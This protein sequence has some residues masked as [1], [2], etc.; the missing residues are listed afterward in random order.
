MQFGWENNRTIIV[1]IFFLFASWSKMDLHRID[2][3]SPAVNS[4]VINGMHTCDD[5]YGKITSHIHYRE[6]IP[7]LLLKFDDRYNK[8]RNSPSV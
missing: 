4:T 6:W 5:R 3:G 1:G 8:R 7:Q 2:T